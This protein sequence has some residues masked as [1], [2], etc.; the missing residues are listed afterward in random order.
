VKQ[1]SRKN[2]RLAKRS[3]ITIEN[4]MSPIAEQFRSI[5]T[6]IQFASIDEEI[7][8]IVVTS[9]G[10]AEGKSTTASNLAVVLTQQGNKVLLIDSDLRKPTVHF[11]F[12]LS[13]VH[14]LTSVLTKQ[15]TLDKAIQTTSEK[16]LFVL[17]SGPKPPNPAEVLDSNAMDHIIQDIKK[18]FDYIIFDTPPL[19]YVADAQILAG[20]T[21]GSILIIASG[22]TEKDEALKA[23]KLLNHSK[24]KIL[25]VILNGKKMKENN[26][27]YGD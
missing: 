6:N 11:T 3:L 4:P 14:G 24:S 7:K 27:Y 5:R 8:T 10:Q 22:V 9:P 1:L 16:D 19:S 12:Q 25:G 17:T 13:N 21:D 18:E 26:Y 20:K 15:L 23:K 2:S